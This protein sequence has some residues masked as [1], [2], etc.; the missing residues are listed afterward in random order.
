[1][2]VAAQGLV[3]IVLGAIF[4]A[5][6]VVLSK[7]NVAFGTVSDNL[8][9]LCGLSIA[10]GLSERLIPDLLERSAKDGRLDVRSSSDHGV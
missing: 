10:A 8:L 3:R 1:M 7:G 5:V 6:L 9:A 4:G 2:T